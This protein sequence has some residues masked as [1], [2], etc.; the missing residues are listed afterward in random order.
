VSDHPALGRA[1]FDRPYLLLTLTQLFWAI[2]IVLGRFIAGTVPPVALSTIRW[3]GA[4]L[5]VLPFA[6][7]HLVA[8][9]PAIRR[10]LPVML[11][12]AATGIATYNTMAYHGLEQTQ[13]IN[14]LLM[15]SSGPLLIALWSLV[16]FR[17]RLTLA[18]LFGILA[19]LTGVAVIILRGD[20]ASLLTL[21]LNPGDLWMLAALMIYGL[22]TTMLRKRP[23]IHPLSFIAFTMGAGALMLMPVWAIEYFVAGR[24]IHATPAAFAV[25]VYV[26]IFPSLVAY[27]FFNRGVELIGANR[28][29][30]FFHL[31]PVFGSIIAMVFL[32]ERP[33]AFHAVGYALIIGG[34]IVAQLGARRLPAA[35]P[36]AA[37]AVA[38]RSSTAAPG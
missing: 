27:L 18:Q 28:A 21:Q 31:M 11:F 32:G 17:D 30:P 10:A 22:Y 20:L 34:I 38:P 8:D 9:W 29:G 19:S 33:Q 36:V 12:L 35:P 26:A 37:G 24:A 2:N 5:L 23:R 6:W 4:A 7:R 16:L 25:L 3:S 13:A 14:G 15:Q 1:F